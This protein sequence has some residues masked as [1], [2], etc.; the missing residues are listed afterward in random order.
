MQRRKFA[1]ILAVGLAAGAIHSPAQNGPARRTE[2]GAR[3]AVESTSIASIGY[4]RDTKALEIEFRS[5]AVY[6]YSGVPEAVHA[7]LLAAKSKGRYFS[8]HIR[9]RYD[10]VQMKVSVP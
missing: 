9:G 8:Q 10:F 3:A 5:G 6:R 4:V 1:L 2:S 7:A